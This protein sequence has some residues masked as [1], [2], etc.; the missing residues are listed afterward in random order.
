MTINEFCSLDAESQCK[1]VNAQLE[2][3]GKKNFKDGN[4]PFTLIQAK[5]AFKPGIKE[6]NNRF[7]T[8]QQLVKIVEAEE[9]AEKQPEQLSEEE[10]IKLKALLA[11]G[12]HEILMKI[13]EKYDYI[14]GYI[15]KADTGIQ[16]AKGKGDFKNTSVRVYSETWALWQDYCKRNNQ[17][18]ATELLNSALQEFISRH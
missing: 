10:I 9:E 16:L 17:Y 7:L 1:I 14:T 8:R 3:N 13:T 6:V 11:D 12:R 15:L 2:K 5:K 18:N 4:I